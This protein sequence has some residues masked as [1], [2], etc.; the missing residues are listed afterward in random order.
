MLPGGDKEIYHEEIDVLHLSKRAE[1]DLRRAGLY[2]VGD[3]YLLGKERISLLPGVGPSCLR[4]IVNALESV[5]VA[6]PQEQPMEELYAEV[7]KEEYFQIM[8]GKNFTIAKSSDL[9]LIDQRI[10]MFFI[11]SGKRTGNITRIIRYVCSEDPGL[12]PGYSVILF[13]QPHSVY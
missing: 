11:E 8:N 2:T 13:Q 9:Y 4:E 3:V 1:Y 10:N 12:K 7:S 6:I 5:G